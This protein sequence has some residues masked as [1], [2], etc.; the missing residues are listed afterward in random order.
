MLYMDVA[1]GWMG[2]V[3][4]KYIIVRID[5]ANKM[6]GHP[7][8][9]RFLPEFALLISQFRINQHKIPVIAFLYV[10]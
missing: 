9:V 6:D 10:L 5:D 8:L 4:V 3:S 1:K 7:F 2:A